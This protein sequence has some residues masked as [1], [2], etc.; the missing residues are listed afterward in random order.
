MKLSRRDRIIFLILVVVAV[1]IAGGLLLIKPQ[2]ENM[3]AAQ[4]RLAAK[5]QERDELQAK[6]DR[7]PGLQ[8]QLKEDVNKVSE[9]QKSFLNEREYNEAHNISMYIKNLLAKGNDSLEIMSIS[10]TDSEA[11]NLSQYTAYET[12]ANYDMKFD[13][14]IAHQMGDEEYWMHENSYPAAM[15]SA[16]VG[17]TVVT[18]GYRCPPEDYQTVYKMMDA[19]A[20]NKE[21][22]YLNTISAEYTVEE[23][24]TPAAG[25]TGEEEEAFIEGEV[26]ITVYEV[27]YMDPADVD[28][29]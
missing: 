22:I 20:N 7:L 12:N 14:D 1:F 18:I 3:E 16:T 10:F 8:Q 5:E 27:Y 4:A 19:I 6:I 25:T 23:A 28:K 29:I 13:A 9:T 21:N 24:S 17:G 15:P 2:Y 26:T 11:Q